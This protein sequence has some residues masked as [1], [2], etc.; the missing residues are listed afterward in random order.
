[1]AAECPP[2]QAI[3]TNSKPCRASIN[4]GVSQD[5]KNRVLEIFTVVIVSEGINIWIDYIKL[6]A[7]NVLNVNTSFA[8]TTL[9]DK[10]QSFVLP[11][12]AS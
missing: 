12:M 6:S 3:S 11:S 5:L 4:F 1:M 8:F 7:E 10:C 9:P 2:P